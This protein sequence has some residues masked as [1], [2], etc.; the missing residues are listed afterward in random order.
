MEAV[1]QLAGGI[2]HDFNNI[3]QAILGYGEIAYDK[4]GDNSSLKRYLN[5]ILRASDRAK[6][7][8]RQLLAFSRRQV[9]DMRNVDLNHVVLDLVEMIRQL[10]GP[11]ITLKTDLAEE[12]GTVRADAGQLE[13]ILVNLCVNSRDAMTEGGTIVIKTENFNIDQEFVVTHPWATPGEY[14]RVTVS[15]T[16]WGMDEDTLTQIFEPFFT[17]KG[18]NKGTGLGL[19]TVYGLVKQSIWA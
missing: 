10:I 17:T 9:L 18:L 8:V 14:V 12:L 4:A 11:H 5:E 15:D 7:L 1:G 16:G 2:A 3:L 13:Q 6:N 19:S